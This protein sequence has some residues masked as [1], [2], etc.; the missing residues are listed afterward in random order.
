MQD[1]LLGMDTSKVM[2]LSLISNIQA[3]GILIF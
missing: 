1:I 3:L 2:V